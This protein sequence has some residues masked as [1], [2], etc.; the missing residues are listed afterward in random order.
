[1]RIPVALSL[2]CAVS[3]LGSTIAYAEPERRTLSM[4]DMEREVFVQLPESRGAARPILIVLH[5]GTRPAADIFSRS[6]WSAVAQ[7]EG[8][9]LAAPQGVDNQWNDGRKETISGKVSTANDVGFLEA[10]IGEL[11]AKDGGDPTAVFMTGVSNGGIMTFAFACARAN[12]LAGIA[13]VISKM[14]KALAAS[15]TPARPIPTVFIAGTADQ[16]MVFEGEGTSM[17]AHR[18]DPMTSVPETI[19]FWRTVNGCAATTREEQLPDLERS[20]NSTVTKISFEPCTKRPV[21]FYRVNGG[22]HWQP[23]LAKADVPARFARL[24]GP[25]N[26]DIEGAEV[27]WSFFKSLPRSR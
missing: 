19:A 8:L 21:L 24:L 13:P 6:A 27:I 16:V 5:G 26:Q 1:M 3:L 12:L 23:S 17:L 18:G 22:G 10:L 15:C 20:D 2:L 14:S 9:I 25:Q 4:G 7:R 11:V